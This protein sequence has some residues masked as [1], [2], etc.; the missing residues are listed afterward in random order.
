MRE[1][2]KPYIN[3]Y[4]IMNNILQEA[5]NV[6]KVDLFGQL[7]DNVKYTYPIAKAI[8]DMGHTVELIFTD[9]CATMKTI[10]SLVLNDE[11]DRLKVENCTMTRDKC[12]EYV[13]NWKLENDVYL[14]NALGMKDDPQFK[15]L[16]GVMVAPCTSK[17]QVPF[18]QKVIK[19]DAAHMSFGKYTLIQHMPSWQMV[20]YQ[21]L[22]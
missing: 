16:M 9:R 10:I 4:A 7:E 8:E 21:H 17:N 6:P 3:E 2:L 18:L 5:H 15:F 20:K 12:W 13:N 11:L 22:D 14:S 1:I 19:A